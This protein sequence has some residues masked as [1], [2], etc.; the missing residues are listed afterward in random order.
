MTS[1]PNELDELDY[2]IQLLSTIRRDMIALESKFNKQVDQLISVHFS[3]AAKSRLNSM[4]R[5][6]CYHLPSRDVAHKLTLINHGAAI[7]AQPEWERRR[8]TLNRPAI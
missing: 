1:A 3:A 4:F 7:T 6:L 8:Y 5:S 2:L